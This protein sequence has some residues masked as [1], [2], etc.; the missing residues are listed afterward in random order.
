MASFLTLLLLAAITTTTNAAIRYIQNDSDFQVLQSDLKVHVLYIVNSGSESQS[1]YVKSDG[2]EQY[3]QQKHTAFVSMAEELHGAAVF[4]VLD[5]GSATNG[6]L[7]T[8]VSWKLPQFPALVMF[9]ETPKKNPYTEDMYRTMEVLYADKALSS[10]LNDLKER[11]KA[12]IPAVYITN[13]TTHQDPVKSLEKIFIKAKHKMNVVILIGK[14]KQ[15]PH[16]YRALSIELHDQGVHFVYIRTMESMVEKKDKYDFDALF[17]KLEI[18]TTPALVALTSFED[19]GIHWSDITT[20]KV[21][22]YND[23]KSFLKPFCSETARPKKSSRVRVQIEMLNT[24]TFEEYVIDSTILWVIYFG[25]QSNI[26]ILSAASTEWVKTQ[27][28]LTRKYG[29]ISLGAVNCDDANQP[30]CDLYGGSG[31]YRVF[32]VGLEDKSDRLHPVLSRKQL[33]DLHL[34]HQ[35]KTL[36]EAVEAVI[37]SIPHVVEVLHS[38]LEI[39][40]FAQQAETDNALPV[41]FFTENEKV[42]AIIRAVSVALPGHNVAFAVAV[43]IDKESKAHVPD[44]PE[45]EKRTFLI[46]YD[47][48]Q[49]GT[50]NYFNIIRFLLS[51]LHK[52]P[53]YTSQSLKAGDTDVEDLSGVSSS[54]IVPYLNKE[55]QKKLCDGSKICVI[56][57]FGNHI[58][59]LANPESTLSKYMDTFTKVAISSKQQKEP[60]VFMWSNGQ[61]QKDFAEAFEVG[62]YQMPTIAVYSL[63]KQRFATMIGVFEAEN[64]QDFL[65]G[66]ITGRIGTSAIGVV[67]ELRDE[68]SFDEIETENVVLLEDDNEDVSDIMDGII[69]AEKEQKRVFKKAEEKPKKRHRKGRSRRKKKKSKKASKDEFSGDYLTLQTVRMIVSK[70]ASDFFGS[71]ADAMEKFKTISQH[72][73]NDQRLEDELM[74]AKDELEVLKRA[75]ADMNKELREAKELMQSQIQARERVLAYRAKRLEDVMEKYE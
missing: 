22:S 63:S 43:K 18:E 8:V 75:N 50:Y 24:T 31:I 1:E 69:K 12:S 15:I 3:V 37:E 62:L 67:S 71:A 20:E 53:G 35:Y 73:F 47:K 46:G 59:T 25:S 23:V 16:V 61:C 7:K 68:C 2:I 49:A 9:F 32:P 58:D 28:T 36:E 5:L 11:I 40:R 56:G 54:D 72:I 4:D 57:F 52:Y 30:L 44:Q 38:A 64:L 55:N 14:T 10:G 42:S 51:V 6:M 33:K 19:Q 65:K 27:N 29:I 39:S 74:T 26:E 66:V 13:I 60:F 70:K 41:L 34:P 48:R 21:N 45:S 17:R